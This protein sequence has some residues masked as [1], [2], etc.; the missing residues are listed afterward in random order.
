[1]AKVSPYHTNSIEEPPKNREVY[2]DHDDCFEGKKIEKKHWETGV[3]ES[4]AA[5]CVL[6][7]ANASSAEKQS[8]NVD[9]SVQSCRAHP[10]PDAENLSKLCRPHGPAHPHVSAWGQSR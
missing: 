4:H 6:S 8:P 10:I 2:H 7:S 5:R 3:A 1:M 9:R